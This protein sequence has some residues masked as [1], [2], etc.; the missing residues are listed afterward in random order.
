MDFLRIF[1]LLYSIFT[2]HEENEN[3]MQLCVNTTLLYYLF[4]LLGSLLGPKC[5]KKI[6]KI[7]TLFTHSGNTDWDDKF[8]RVCVCV[9][10]I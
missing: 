5:A 9:C 6:A 4:L 7:C 1:I 10:V 2:K 8:V 3:Q